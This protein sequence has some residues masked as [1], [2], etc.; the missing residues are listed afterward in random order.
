MAKFLRNFI[1]GRMNKSV[2][3]RVLPDGEYVDAM[4]VRMG[5]TEQSEVG[6]AENTK[7]NLPLTELRY[8]DGTQLSIDAKCIGAIEDS[9]SETIY[10][11][12]HDSNFPVGATGKLD[13]IV[14]YNVFTGILTYNV[15]SIDDGGGL[16]TTLN[17]NPLYLITGVNIVGDLL[18]FTDNYNPPRFINIRPVT[19]RYP[20]PFNDID[21]ITAED[22]LV[23]KRPPIESPALS[24][25]N[26]GGQSNYLTE[27]FISFAYRYRYADGEYSATSQWSDIAFAPNSFFFSPSSFL[28]EGMTNAFNAVQVTYNTGGPLVVGI[29]LLF[30]QSNNN[31][32]KV[33]DNFDKKQLGYGDNALQTYV[34]SNSKIFT[35]LSASE[36]LR[37]YD[38][39]PHYAQA[40]TI[41]GNRLM[42][43][44]YIEG[45]DLL[46]RNGNPLMLEYTANL[47]TT[48]IGS[49]DVP[50]SLD[51]GNYNVDVPIS[52]D[53]S[54]VYIDL[55]GISLTEGSSI[56]LDF[57][58]SHDSWGGSTPYPSTSNGDIDI[59]FTYYLTQD[60]T[61]VFALATSAGFQEAVGTVLG[62]KP[63]YS[64]ISGVETSCDGVTLTD[65]IN[66]GIQNLVSA[67]KYNSGING[68]NEPVKIVT[69]PGS[70]Q[71]GFQ[72]ISMQFVDNLATPTQFWYEYYNISFADASFLKVSNPR[73]LHSN[74]GYQIGIVYMDEF[75]R[76]STALVSNLNDTVHVPCGYSANQN[77]IQVTIPQFQIAPSWATRYKFVI[78]PDAENY[79]V[80]YSNLFFTEE[81]TGSSYFLLEGENIRKVESG[82]RYI[83]KADTNG[84]LTNCQYATVLEKDAK[85]SG[86]IVPVGGGTVPAG[87][88]MK[89]KPTGFSVDTPDNSY[90]NFGRQ[91]VCAGK[92]GYYN[93]MDYS[94]SIADP[95]NPGQYLDFS[96]PAGSRIIVDFYW[97][98]VG[99]GASCEALKYGLGKTYVSSSDY[100]NI[101]DWFIGEHIDLTLDEG[102]GNWGP[103]QFNPTIGTNPATIPV[104]I[105][106]PN[107]QFFRDP[108]SNQLWL[109]MTTGKSCTGAGYPGS[110]KFCLSAQIEV[111]RAVALLIFE[112]EPTDALPDVFYENNLSFGI[113]SN[114]NHMGNV[115]DQD[116][117][118]G[119]PAIVDTD[120]FNCFCFGNG[121]ESFKIRDSIV[122]RGFGLGERVNTVA[123]QEY[124]ESERF[125]DITYSG[126]FNA[127]TNVN[128]LNEFNLGLL[129]YKNL[130]TSFGPIYKMDG[131]ETDVL[132]L[133]EDK[134]S[135]VLAGKNLLS[136]S[137][138]GGAI[139]SVPEVLGTQIARTEKYGISF[140]PESYV[141]WGANRYFTDV[142]RGAVIQLIGDSYSNE[143]IKIIS[144][145]GMRTW[146]RDMFNNSFSTQKLGG[147]DPYMNEYVLTTNDTPI[148]TNPKC[149]ACGTTQ[150]LS[151][152]EPFTYCVDL[153]A[154]VGET[155]IVWS[156][157]SETGGQVIVDVEYDGTTYSSGPTVNDGQ[158]TFYKDNILVETATVTITPTAGE[159]WV[160][161]VTAECPVPEE[162]TIVQI[163][164][165]NNSEAGET[166]HVQY[167]YTNGTFISPLQ[168]NLVTFIS[169][170][171]NPLVSYYNVT[172]GYVGTGGFPPEFSTLTMTSS[173]V[174][175]D[176][177]VFDITNDKL[178]YLRTN[179]LYP[180]TPTSILTAIGLS[181]I[182]SPITGSSPNYN[183]NFTVPDKTLG[184]V[185]YLIWDYRDSIPS[186]LCYS[187][188]FV[189][190]KVEVCC[191]CEECTTEC[192]NVT[193]TNL[194]SV[195]TA[196]IEVG[197]TTGGACGAPSFIVTLDPEEVYET[198]IQV[199]TDYEVLDGIASV[200]L[201]ECADC[202][203]YVYVNPQGSGLTAE[204]K[205]SDCTTEEEAT[206][207]VD[208]GDNFK[209]C[210]IFGTTPIVEVGSPLNL[211]MVNQCRCCEDNS[212]TQWKIYDITDDSF[213]AWID[214]GGNET[215][216]VFLKFTENYICVQAGFNPNLIYGDCTIQ[217]YNGCMNPDFC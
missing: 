180:N 48:S 194:S 117:A 18:F 94:L 135:Y 50:T 21:E 210:C 126:V 136:D 209:F 198:C 90:L 114:G 26:L 177:F 73:S 121:A 118:L 96:V 89:M 104:N 119:I 201:T 82:D 199:G 172:S 202:S 216:Q 98:R 134:I 66:C 74:R 22:L 184:N 34:F 163:V 44:N 188:A 193:I 139:A 59:G 192:V 166:T 72:V 8:I 146:F 45:Y 97:D 138:G 20:N 149:L 6:V 28:N 70:D 1:A 101:Y 62:I 13:L 86:F 153:G 113:D 54:V 5:S 55:A 182:A 176:D 133:Q 95:N 9:A 69:S 165:T 46:D 25:V 83:V 132:V 19:N 4:N 16:N 77:T 81:A 129:N 92:G 41:M 169:G 156:I 56:N 145:Q 213:I 93:R 190:P 206:I 158:I 164:V 12:V 203:T 51:S 181:S 162:L 143:Q 75:N 63:V 173:Q 3:Q 189:D 24:L 85:S 91:R 35:I 131:R 208:E 23:I 52:I 102:N 130:E 64:P 144:E 43:G 14:S 87:V 123:A 142:K 214:C 15:I 17:F 147:F 204:I 40:Q 7:G 150:T 187:G 171:A 215:S 60:Y 80:I 84:P 71:I 170:T 196:E 160:L 110:R 128:K 191:N 33:I 122:G 217:P 68:L 42:Y 167:R 183:A 140:N 115:Q 105:G 107:M 58:L 78:K 112:T 36:L 186:E 76:S 65:Q 212:C 197:V 200:L 39:V 127:E 31:V 152:S 99:V 109:V 106:Y 49:E 37:L 168:S 161:N 61:S 148:P 67:S 88:Y 108:T 174:P 151:L 57:R 205:Y 141:Q 185:L 11:F 47:L 111:Y 178:R 30:K 29:D 175:P 157:I 125:A 154:V 53:D 32:I 159:T 2:D 38:N 211:Y 103:P 79:E 155:T 124:K 116:I 100:T 179:T 10:W 207:F 120:F 137:T 195:N 27:R